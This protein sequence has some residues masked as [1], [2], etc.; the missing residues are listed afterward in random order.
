MAKASGGTPSVSFPKGGSGKMFDK[1]HAGPQ[2]PGQTAQTKSGDGG[3]FASGGSKKM[4]GKG[5]ADAMPSA[6]TARKS[7]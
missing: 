5:H 1:Q 2:T 3:K 7:Q 4:Y 6:V